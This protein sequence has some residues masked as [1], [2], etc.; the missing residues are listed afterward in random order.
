MKTK[1]LALLLFFIAIAELKAQQS[2]AILFT[3]NG[4]RFQVVLNGVIQ[5]TSAQTNVKLTGLNA[6]NYKARILFENQDLPPVDF[7]LFFLNQGFEVTWNIKKNNKGNYV[8]RYV[9][10]VEVAQAPPTPSTQ[11]VV[12]YSSEPRR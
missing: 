4:E 1:L 11:S 9:S 12:I 7:N 6:P 3:E 8:V 2:N 5:N 10:Q